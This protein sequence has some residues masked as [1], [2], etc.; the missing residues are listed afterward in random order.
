[1]LIMPPFLIASKAVER[2]HPSL[3][4][5]EANLT[6]FN[7]SNAVIAGV[8]QTQRQSPFRYISSIGMHLTN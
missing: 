3:L 8:P 4:P 1:M 5:D 6:E 7:K 2:D